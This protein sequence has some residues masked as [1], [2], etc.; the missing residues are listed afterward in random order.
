MGRRAVRSAP[1]WVAAALWLA[2][3]ACSNPI[4]SY[5]ATR[6][7]NRS[8]ATATMWTLTPSKTNTPRPTRTRTP[9]VTQT[10]TRTK[11]PTPVPTD[12]PFPTDTL[13]EGSGTPLPPGMHQTTH[14]WTPS[15]SQN[16]YVETA[17]LTKFSYV[18][19]VGWKKVPASGSNLTSWAGPTQTGGMV[20]VLVFLTVKSNDSAEQFAKKDLASLTSNSSVKIISQGKFVNDDGIDAY[21]AVIVISSQGTNLQ[22]VMY[23]FQK[24]GYLVAGGY[25]RLVDQNKEQDAIVDASLRTLRYE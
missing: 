11:T 7:S 3:M 17:G 8:T 2:S 1:L 24:R 10:H 18:P 12:T 25:M 13:E 21:K 16:R 14:T 6:D 9:T 22:M 20:C 15:S 5:Y 19:P 4:Q 23:Y